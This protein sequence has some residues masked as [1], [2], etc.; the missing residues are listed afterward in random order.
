[1]VHAEL[2]DNA[3]GHQ[4]S[5]DCVNTPG[6]GTVTNLNAVQGIG[7]C[8]QGV[9]QMRLCVFRTVN[10]RSGTPVGQYNRI[11]ASGFALTSFEQARTAFQH[12]AHRVELALDGGEV[13]VELVDDAVTVA[14]CGYTV[15]Y[16]VLGLV[17]NRG[18]A[19]AGRSIAQTHQDDFEVTLLGTGDA[20]AATVATI[21]AT[22]TRVAV[23]QVGELDA[24]QVAADDRQTRSGTGGISGLNARVTVLGFGSG[25]SPDVVGLHDDVE[26]P[27]VPAVATYA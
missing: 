5:A 14:R 22:G 19:G 15:G 18:A 25:S 4:Q 24:T 7:Q 10:L 12:V 17:G 27:L 23:V 9:V 11:V 26:V 1:R 8:G 20:G 3:G 2:V 16:D 21:G 6:E 13:G